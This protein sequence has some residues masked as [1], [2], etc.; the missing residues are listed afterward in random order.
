MFTIFLD[1]DGQAVS[2]NWADSFL[3]ER[4]EWKIS[5]EGRIGDDVVVVQ[6]ENVW[7]FQR[8]G[9]TYVG[10]GVEF[11]AGGDKPGEDYRPE[12]R[13]AEFFSCHWES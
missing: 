7:M 9:S 6:L 10:A 4:V 3:G 1:E 5:P 11:W 12:S 8:L 2:F 13:D